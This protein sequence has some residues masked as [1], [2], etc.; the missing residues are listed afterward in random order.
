MNRKAT[1]LVLF[2]LLAAWCRADQVV[3]ESGKTIVGKVIAETEERVTIRISETITTSFPKEKVRRV[4]RDDYELPDSL[5]EKG[6]AK[7]EEPKDKK[8]LCFVQVSG[9]IESK[10]MVAA[11]HHSIRHSE[12]H[13][14]DLI[15]FEID[16]PG[17]RLDLMQELLAVIESVEEART[18]AYVCGG[19]HGGAYSAGAVL[20]VACEDIVMAPGTAIG[21]AAPIRVTSRG[22]SAAGEKTVSAV[23]AKVR[24]LAQMNGHP[25]ELCAAMVDATVELREAKVGGKSTFLSVTKAAEEPEPEVELGEWITKSGKLL[26]LTAVEARRLGV[27]CGLARSRRELTEVLELEAGT[28]VDMKTGE[29]LEEAL[30]TR[31]R[32]LTKLDGK[33][34]AYEARGKALQPRNFKYGRIKKAQ[35]FLRPGDF[36]DGGRLWRQRTDASLKAL[37]ACLAACRKKLELARNYPE[38]GIDTKPVEKKMTDLLAIRE[39]VAAERGLR[40]SEK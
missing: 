1:L 3:L 27:A 30:D 2:A 36:V 25:G 4:V 5:R 34:A 6:G 9:P 7:G 17:G 24:S 14:P 26:T 37:D 22:V 19:P 13:E 11:V 21:A 12:H 20:A 23:T 28:L 8:T 39:R 32:Y 33:I 18:V 15:V 10:L 38:L 16:T 35:G 29:A 40:G 31:R